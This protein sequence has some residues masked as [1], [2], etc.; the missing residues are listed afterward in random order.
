MPLLSGQSNNLCSYFLSK[1]NFTHFQPNFI[2]IDRNIITEVQNIITF[3][4]K[5]R[6]TFV[7][8]KKKIFTDEI[9]K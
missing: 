1:Q 6:S 4:I 2:K 3:S 7:V 8:L 5:I 9:K